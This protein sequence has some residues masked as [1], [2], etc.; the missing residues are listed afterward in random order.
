MPNWCNN[1]M[2]ISGTKE[3]MDNV[4]SALK[5]GE[6]F[7]KLIPIPAEL[8]IT[9][10]SLGHNT[11]EQLE[12]EEKESVNR[13][14]YGYANWYDYCVNEWG[15]K[16]DISLVSYQRL[17]ETEISVSFDTAWG[18]AIAAYEK[19]VDMGYEIT[20]YYYEPGMCFAGIFEDGVDDFYE[21][22]DMTSEQV[23]DKLPEALDE[24]FCISESMA[25]WEE[26]NQEIE[27]N[28]GIDS[29]NE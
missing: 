7:S 24:M 17:S 21:L 2:N 20:A 12:L 27:L 25:E 15:T 29:I 28:D 6:L 23:L 14:K 1:N 16:W 8:N 13:E 18:P 11:P 4:E 5:E 10:G 22:G 3:M 26:E 9:A 19:M